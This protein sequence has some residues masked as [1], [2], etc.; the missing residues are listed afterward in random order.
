MVLSVG[1]RGFGSSKDLK[2]GQPIETPVVHKNFVVL[3]SFEF[4]ETTLTEN[5][6]VTVKHNIH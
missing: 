1:D 2:Y 6:L 4:S 3:P 5:I